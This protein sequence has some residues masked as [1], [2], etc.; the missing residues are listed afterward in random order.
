[1]YDKFDSSVSNDFTLKCAEFLKYTLVSLKETL[2]VPEFLLE[3]QGIVEFG[4]NAMVSKM[5]CVFEEDKKKIAK[6]V[7]DLEK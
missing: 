7:S 2:K 3:M 5:E 6:I 1:M 4:M